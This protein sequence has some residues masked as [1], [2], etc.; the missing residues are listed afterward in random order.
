MC[1][2]KNLPCDII[3]DHNLVKEL[4]MDVLYSEYVVVWDSVRLIMQKIKN[5]KWTDLNLM[6]QEDPGA[7]KEQSIQLGKIF[8]ANDRMADLEQEVNKLIHPPKFEQVI[9]LNFIKQ[10]KYIFGGNLG[11]W[12]GPPV[13]IPLKDEANPYHAQAFPIPVIHLED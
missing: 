4:Q 3:I 10:Y 12:T 5:G 9:L 1:Y 11:E 2:R 13:D 8:D 6:D 7:I